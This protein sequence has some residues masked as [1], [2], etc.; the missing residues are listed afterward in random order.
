MTRARDYLVLATRDFSKATWLNEQMATDGRL[1][2]RRGW[3]NHCQ[4]TVLNQKASGVIDCLIEL[5]DGWVIIYHKTFPG[6][7]ELLA[8]RT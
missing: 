1:G 3:R 5:P 6:R 2:W 8:A 7:E 4:R